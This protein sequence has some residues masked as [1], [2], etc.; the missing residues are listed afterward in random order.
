MAAWHLAVFWNRSLPSK[1]RRSRALSPLREAI[2]TIGRRHMRT[3]SAAEAGLRRVP[4]EE[5]LPAAAAGAGELTLSIGWGCG[6]APN[7]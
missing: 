6:T 5:V 2:G 7:G 1:K 3:Q 4:G